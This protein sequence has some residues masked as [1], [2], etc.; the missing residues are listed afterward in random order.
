MAQAITNYLDGSLANAPVLGTLGQPAKNILFYDHMF[1]SSA[2]ADTAQWNETI[3][4][5]TTIVHSTTVSGGIWTITGTTGASVQMQSWAP[6]A[7]IAAGRRVYIEARVSVSSIA[8]NTGTFFIGL[9][10]TAGT[11]TSPALP[12]TAAGVATTSPSA[13]DVVGVGFAPS[14]AVLSICQNG[15][16]TATAQTLATAAASTYYRVGIYI[17]GRSGV[18]FFLDGVKVGS[19]ITG[20]SI[21][22][23]ALFL[24][25]T[26][27]NGSTAKAANVDYIWAVVEGHT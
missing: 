24:D 4:S 22:D 6:L 1:N 10:D 17:D 18:T 15:S 21:P 11:G 19:T 12:C 9:Q 7:T 8:A 14:G 16:T 20:S 3:G 27:S 23:A 13:I 25:M 2:S 5:S 26:M